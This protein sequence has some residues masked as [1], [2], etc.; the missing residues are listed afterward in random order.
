MSFDVQAE[1][2]SFFEDQDIKPTVDG[3][4]VN[5]TTDSNLNGQAYV[6]VTDAKEDHLENIEERQPK[7]SSDYRLGLH[8]ASFLQFLM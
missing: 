5:G 8:S 4:K 3:A 1:C 2:P 6:S 7:L